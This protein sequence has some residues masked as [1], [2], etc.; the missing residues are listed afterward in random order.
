[1][2]RTS[3]I[4]MYTPLLIHFLPQQQNTLVVRETKNCSNLCKSETRTLWPKKFQILLF[5]LSTL[6]HFRVFACSHF[7][8]FACRL[9]ASLCISILSVSR[10]RKTTNLLICEK[11][12]IVLSPGTQVCLPRSA[13]A[14]CACARVCARAVLTSCRRWPC[15]RVRVCARVLCLPRC[16][17][18]PP[19]RT[20]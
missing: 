12:E 3:N 13:V 6:S 8:I 20:K 5:S 10:Q 11:L 4:L 18:W 17:R 2:Y 15:V 19:L 16:R 9:P 14:L 1:M 7:H